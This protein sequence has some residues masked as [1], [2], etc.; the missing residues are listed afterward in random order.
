MIVVFGATGNVGRIL[1]ERLVERSHAVRAVT[2]RQADAAFP[3]G[4]EVRAG[5]LSVPETLPPLLEGA[6]AVFAVFHI[7][8]DPSQ[9]AHL[10]AALRSSAVRR[11]VMLSSLTVESEIAGD[12][13]GQHHRAA[14]AAL[15][16][17]APEFV[18]LRPGTFMSNALH[19]ADQ[20]RRG[21]VVRTLDYKASAVIDEAD[22][23][24]VAAK[25]LTAAESEAGPK[26][27]TGPARVS[28]AD[29]VSRVGEAVGRPLSCDP[30]SPEEAV[31]MVQAN[32]PGVDGA[33]VVESVAS[34]RVP[35]AEPR[36]TV[37]TILG[38]PAGD[39]GAWARR[40]AHRFR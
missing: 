1:V 32:M 30:L 3:A 6:S 26:R 9:P 29:M 25:I 23:A 37:A 33:A 7:P 38:R 39:F 24:E 22:I 17:A 12:L 13:V 31:A 28:I 5:D 21:D 27:M 16:D 36:P 11:V 35:W 19:W 15:Q 40:N 34:D 10:A 14:E 8:G 4:V 18:A 20:V 2:R